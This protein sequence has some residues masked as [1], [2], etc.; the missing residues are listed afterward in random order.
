MEFFMSGRSTSDCVRLHLARRRGA[1][2]QA[3]SQ[4]YRAHASQRPRPGDG[5]IVAAC[6]QFSERALRKARFG[7]HLAELHRTRRERA[8][9]MRGLKRWRIDC[10]LKIHAAVH[11]LKEQLDRPLVLLA[12]AGWT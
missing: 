7:G 10:G 6:A 9:K 5:Q 4:A 3:V 12:A 1:A 11:M 8:R 2:H